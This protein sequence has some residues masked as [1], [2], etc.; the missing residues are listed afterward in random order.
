MLTQ[1]APHVSATPVEDP[2]A[3]STASVDVAALAP[4]APTGPASPTIPQALRAI[5]VDS[6]GFRDATAGYIRVATAMA[7]AQRRH[8]D[9]AHRLGELRVEQRHLTAAL[10]AATARE[11]AYGAQHRRVK[12]ALEDQIVALFIDGGETRELEAILSMENATEPQRRR[13]LSEAALTVL[14]RDERE[15]R[16]LVDDA[17]ADRVRLV[18]ER[19]DNAVRV[20]DTAA[21]RDSAIADAAALVPQLAD[22]RTELEIER[23]MAEV[24]GADFALVALDAYQRAARTV[25]EDRTECALEWWAVA[26]ISRVEGRHG[27]YGRSTLDALGNTTSRIIGIQLNGERETAVIKDSDDGELD[28]DPNFDRAVGPMQF[29]PSTWRRHAADGNGDVVEDPHN[30]YDAALAAG[31]YLCKASTALNTDD[32][33]RRAYFSYNHSVAYVDNVLRWA[34]SYRELELPELDPLTRQ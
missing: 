29:I 9:A 13:V 33:L 25:N 28:G 1:G 34:H 26:G 3:A 21:A 30:L 4:A 27:T 31:N 16:T 12:A 6:P 20:S 15:L 18:A 10:A 14:Q 17:S 24:V 7:D 11:A 22:V 5:E 2:V 32:G 8:R 19:S 23:A